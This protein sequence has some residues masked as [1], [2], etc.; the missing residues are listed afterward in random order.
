MIFPEKP[1][2][3]PAP[4]R[5]AEHITLQW[6]KIWKNIANIY[7]GFLFSCPQVVSC[8]QFSPAP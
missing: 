6:L 2:L 4:A 8:T 3:V 7:K 1:V 5:W